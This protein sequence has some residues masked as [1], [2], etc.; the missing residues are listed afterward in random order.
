MNP[1]N[2]ELTPQ[3]RRRELVNL[4]ARTLTCERKRRR[5]FSELA[6]IHPRCGRDDESLS[7]LTANRD[8]E[9]MRP[10]NT[11]C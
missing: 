4:V 11:S 10:V 8:E 6:Q 2:D 3:E 5:S 1:D 7:V 9:T